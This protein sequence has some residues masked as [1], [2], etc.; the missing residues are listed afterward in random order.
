[1]TLFSDVDIILHKNVLNVLL[2][3]NIQGNT[4]KPLKT[5][6]TNKVKRSGFG[7]FHLFCICIVVKINKW[8]VN[9]IG[10]DGIPA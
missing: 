9:L 5:R 3:Y 4:A 6:Q 10:L 8:A 7:S 2:I 1:M